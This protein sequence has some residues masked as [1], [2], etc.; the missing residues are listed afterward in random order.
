MKTIKA[1]AFQHCSSLN[2]INFPEGVE[3][4]GDMAF[5]DSGLESVEIP[6]KSFL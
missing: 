3:Y 1:R 6:S 4:I 5:S 2:A